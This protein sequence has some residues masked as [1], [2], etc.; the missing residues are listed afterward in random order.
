MLHVCFELFQTKKCAGSAPVQP[1]PVNL[2]KYRLDVSLKTLKISKKALQSATVVYEEKKV[3]FE[4]AQKNL[5]VAQSVRSV[6]PTRLGV[7]ATR[8]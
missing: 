7:A 4:Q 1:N 6:F 3:V 2:A 8:V 5:A